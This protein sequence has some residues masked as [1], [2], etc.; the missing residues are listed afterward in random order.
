MLDIF[1]QN[2]D[3]RIVIIILFTVG[4]FGSTI[5]YCLRT[6]SK[7]LDKVQFGLLDDG[8]MHGYKKAFH[9]VLFDQWI[10]NKSCHDIV[11]PIFPNLDYCS[12]LDSLVFYINQFSHKDPVIFVDCCSVEQAQRTQLFNFHKNSDMLDRI[13]HNKSQAW[14][15]TYTDWRDMRIYELREA[16]S[17]YIDQQLQS[18]NLRRHV[19][20]HWLVTDPDSLLHRLPDEICRMMSY[21]GLTL[22]DSINLRQFYKKWLS[23][24]QYVIDEFDLVIDIID[25]LNT[26]KFYSWSRLSLCSEAILQARLRHIGYE[27]DMTNLAISAKHI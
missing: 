14:N 8:S 13:M 7:E 1:F 23:K 26:D 17:F 4:N 12:T 9:P 5:E 3:N 10:D 2:R 6:F 15:E 25:H 21:C 16:L 22:S 11:T 27:L 20:D 18:V 24:Q 19:P